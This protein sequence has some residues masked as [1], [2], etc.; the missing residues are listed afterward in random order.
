[1]GGVNDRRS[2]PTKPFDSQRLAK[3]TEDVESAQAAADGDDEDEDD[4][5]AEWGVEP[6]VEFELAERPASHPHVIAQASTPAEPPRTPTGTTPPQGV[7]L[8]AGT[9]PPAEIRSR[10]PT[11]Y[12]PLTTSVLAEVARRTQTLDMPAMDPKDTKTQEPEPKDRKTPPP[13][14]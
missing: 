3:L 11:V 13:R 6:V 8:A 4:V 10:A 1:M 2:R 7:R 9:S 14:R 12:D 5:L